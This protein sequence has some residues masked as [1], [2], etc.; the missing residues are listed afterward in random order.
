MKNDAFAP[1]TSHRLAAS[2][3]LVGQVSYIAV[4]QAHAGGH[5]NEHHEIFETYARDQVWGAVHLGQFGGMALLLGGLIALAFVLDTGAGSARWFARLGAAAAATT[6]ALYGVLQA[7]DGV[8]LKQA[9]TAWASAPATEQSARFATAESIR[10][11]EWGVRSYQDYA[12]GLTLAL[13]GTALLMGQ[14]LPRALGLL[15][16]LSGLAY[17]AQGWIAGS[18][19]F[20]SAQSVA[21]VFGWV[22]SLVWMI[23]LGITA[24]RMEPRPPSA[25]AHASDDALAGA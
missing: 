1:R 5:A 10:W 24:W 2:L 8:A 20:S 19:G 17:F 4:T 21:I 12:F 13:L 9:V 16:G 23:W 18:E 3:L 15:F 25:R 11:L 7:V 22:F 6:L 14:R